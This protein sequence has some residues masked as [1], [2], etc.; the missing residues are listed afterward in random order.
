MCYLNVNFTTQCI[1]FS[2]NS[3]NS[4]GST[5]F[6]GLLDRCA[7]SPFAEVYKKYT[8]NSIGGIGYF[9][10]VS[11]A[12]DDSIS[13]D[14]VQV[15]LCTNDSAKCNNGSVKKYFKKGETFSVS[16]MAIDQVAHPVS[17]IIRTSL[18]FSDS[19]L[20]EGQLERSVS[21]ECTKLVFNV[22]SPHNLEKLIL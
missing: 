15:C 19:G 18:N 9:K 7:V 6:G 11:F 10:N 1:Y 21:T 13:S 20:A 2:Q 14:P 5:L 8:L 3:A 12:T 22:V 4:S 17:A 16:L